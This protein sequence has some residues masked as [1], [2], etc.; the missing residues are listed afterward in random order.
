[1]QIKASTAKAQGVPYKLG[2]CLTYAFCARITCFSSVFICL[3]A[4]KQQAAFTP[5]DLYSRKRPIE[6]KVNYYWLILYTTIVIITIGLT[7]A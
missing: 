3:Y 6:R 1:M 7:S 5:E 2:S 4:S